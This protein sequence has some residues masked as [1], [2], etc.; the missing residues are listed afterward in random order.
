MRLLAL[1]ILLTC[2]L[3]GAAGAFTL[4]YTVDERG[5]VLPCG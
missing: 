1:A 5:E 3:P 4:L 2:Y